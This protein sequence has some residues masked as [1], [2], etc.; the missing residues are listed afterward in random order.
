MLPGYYIG[1]RLSYD[2]NLCTVRYIGAVQGTKGEWLGV[3][4]DDPSRGKHN[5]KH[6]DMKYFDCECRTIP[7]FCCSISDRCYNQKGAS[8]LPTP[9]SFVRPNRPHDPRRNFVE[10]IRAKYASED[11][12]NVELPKVAADAVITISGKD[13]EEVGFDKIRRQLADLYG[14]RIVV[15]DG[16][17]IGSQAL[18]SDQ[19]QRGDGV[20]NDLTKSTAEVAIGAA[21]TSPNIVEL[22]LSNNL[23]ES[24]Q[25]IISI[26]SQLPKLSSLN[27]G[28]NRLSDSD[29]EHVEDLIEQPPFSTLTTLSLESCLLKW[30]EVGVPVFNS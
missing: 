3:E 5:G 19:V 17:C 6:G 23:F 28:G 24:W 18:P 10:A 12:T 1:R 2:G 8:S 21:E 13:V 27:I 20:G 16:L 9:A 26:V 15:L 11:L 29:A 22:D 25:D 7:S 4:W 14:L 30:N